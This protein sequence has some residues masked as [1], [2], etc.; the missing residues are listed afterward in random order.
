MI[1]IA[2][3]VI[4]AS[5]AIP[6][7]LRA[8]VQSNETAAIGNLRTLSSSAEAFRTTQNPPAYPASLAAMV[9]AAPPYLDP[10]WLT[11]QRQGYV[12][13]YS[14][15]GDGE[16]FSVSS[17]PRVANVSGINSY[18][19]DHTGIIRRYAQG[20]NVGGDRGCLTNG[21]PI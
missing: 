3:I 4:I 12:F 19:V 1:V 11:N 20:G 18:C 10:T 14:A 21:T 16:T 2:L 15:A 7:S 8:K 17:G 13:A 9:S 6:F 5:L